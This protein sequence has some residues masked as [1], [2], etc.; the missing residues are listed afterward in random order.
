MNSMGIKASNLIP[1][2]GKVAVV[3]PT[4]K[5]DMSEMEYI[6]Y[7]QCLDV[8][9]KY[10]TYILS[11][12]DLDISEYTKLG[13][14]RHYKQSPRFF[15]TSL[16]Y[17]KLMLTRGFYEGLSGYEYILIYQLDCYVFRDELETW[18]NLNYDY[19]G[20]PW[21]CQDLVQWVLKKKRNYPLDMKVLHKLTG[22]KLLGEVGNGGLSLRKTASMIRNLSLFSLRTRYYNGNEDVFMAHYLGA[23]NP[24]FRIPDT[25]TALKFAFDAHPD[26][27]FEMNGGELPFGCH[28]W[29]RQDKGTY[30]NNLD[31]WK[32]HIDIQQG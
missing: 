17:N 25:A 23:L 18:C 7:R 24:F 6:S 10:D 31:F 30:D 29:W 32:T 21:V 22:Y 19:I 2:N 8:L 13:P 9:G 1:N 14:V 12:E 16:R 11:P 20:A 27:A 15:G 3:I 5:S 4:N 28:A 26:T